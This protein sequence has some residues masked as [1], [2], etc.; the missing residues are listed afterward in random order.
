MSDITRRS[1]MKKYLVCIDYSASIHHEVEAENEEQAQIIAFKAAKK[2]LSN[3]DLYITV[4]Y[5]DE[6]KE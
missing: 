2:V 5:V 6:V 4:G 3:D 1:E